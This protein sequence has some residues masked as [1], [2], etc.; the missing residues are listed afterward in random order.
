M[1]YQHLVFEEF[2]R[3]MVPSINAFIG[4]GI[5]FV[6]AINPAIVAEFAHQIYR[7]GHSMLTETI[8][9]TDPNGND[10]DIPLLDGFLNPLEFTRNPANPNVPLTASQA[11]GAIFQGGTRQLGNEIDEFVTEAVRNRLAR[12]AAR[13]RRPE[14]R[15]WPQ[16]GHRGVEPDPAGNCT[17]RPATAQLLPYTSWFDFAFAIKHP[18]TL[19]NFIAAYGT[20]P[21]AITGT[22][23]NRRT[24]A[25][26]LVTDPDFMFA[27]AAVSGVDDIDL[28]MGGLAEKQTPFGSLLGPTFS[29]I[30]EIQLENLQNADRFYYLERLDGLNFLTQLE[31]NSFSELIARN[32]TLDTGTSADVFSRPDFVFNMSAQAACPPAPSTR[33]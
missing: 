9:R 18:E 13:P 6:S 24:A 4:D 22:M 15:A 17:P 2:A 1:Q 32:T 31:G 20:A 3:K 27:D 29:Y 14:H 25:Q 33:R 19:V 11:A 8:A 10:N 28:W 23:A 26:A 16:R 12:P 30:F 21:E 5:N 7:L